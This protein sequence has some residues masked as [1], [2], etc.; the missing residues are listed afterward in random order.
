MIFSTGRSAALCALVWAAVAS[1]CGGEAP[2]PVVDAGA[3]VSA[4]DPAAWVPELAARLADAVRA[5]AAESAAPDLFERAQPSKKYPF[6]EPEVLEALYAGPGRVHRLVGPLTLTEAGAR[7]AERLA[8]LKVDGISPERLHV[9]EHPKWRQRYEGAVA[10]LRAVPLPAAPTPQEV[11]AL[12]AAA[13]SMPN[14]G[15]EA[16]LV[17]RVVKDPALLPA[18][19]KAWPALQTAGESVAVTR[20]RLELVLADGYAYALR[21]LAPGNLA[22]EARLAK[23]AAAPPPAPVIESTPAATEVRGSVSGDDDDAAPPSAPAGASLPPVLTDAK[24]VVRQRLR[25]AIERAT[26]AAEVDATLLEAQP[27]HPQYA[28]VKAALAKYRAVADAGGYVKLEPSGPPL[29]PGSAHPLVAKVQARLAQDG[30][31]TGAPSGVFDAAT[32][33]AVRAFQAQMQLDETGKI[34][35]RTWAELAVPV[36]QRIRKLDRALDALRASRVDDETAYITVNIPDFHLEFWADGKLQMRQRVVVGKPSGTRCD[37]RTKRLTLAFGTPTLHAEMSQLVFAPYWLVTKDIKEKEYDP[38]RAK[39][40]MFY[41]HNGY[42]VID[43]GRPSEWVRQLPGPKNSLGFVKMLFPNEHAVYLHDTPQKAYFERKF[44]AFSHGCVRLHQPR[45]LAQLIL[46]RDGQWDQAR[47]D[48][49]FERWNEMGR[50]TERYDETK[51]RRALKE[52]LD[53]QT[54]VNLKAPLP[55][56]FEYYTAHVDDA[57]RVEFLNDLYDLDKGKWR[58][59]AAPTCVTDSQRAREGADD[60]KDDLARAER[61]AAG[62]AGRIERLIGRAEK[63][64]SGSDAQKGLWRRLKGLAKFGEKQATFAKSVEAAHDAVKT[65]LE[66]RDGEWSKELQSEAVKVRRL[67]DAMEK[68][69]SAARKVCDEVEAAL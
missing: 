54:P 41:E 31:L 19:V 39:D 6:Q 23:R 36:G 58:P 47:F 3:T 59:G 1:G 22:T 2:P 4:R 42:E 48:A 40:P 27:K 15:D 57:G 43:R 46:E 9:D 8:D 60:V 49:L 45:E 32:T 63:L 25:E 50:L 17:E 56:F 69:T 14:G 30:L 28:R 68:Q 10:D 65:K 44:R 29:G 11:A 24:G 7:V 37:E 67:L 26:S 55:V 13:R 62:V 38:E 20:L 35:K 5:R 33:E 52:A 61:E 51:Y 53:L 16:A 34:E 18:W 21:L 12:V 66:R 64:S